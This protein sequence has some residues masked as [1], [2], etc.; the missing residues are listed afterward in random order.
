MHTK[1]EQRAYVIM[2]DGCP[3]RIAIEQDDFVEIVCGETRDEH[4]EFVLHQ[5]ALRTLV[6]LGTAALRRMD[7]RQV[8]AARAAAPTRAASSPS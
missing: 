4:F 3:M 8:S 2:R 1:L 6:G 5:E 7:E